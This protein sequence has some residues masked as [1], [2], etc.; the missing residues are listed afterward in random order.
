[1]PNYIKALKNGFDS[2]RRA[3]AAKDSIFQ[4]FTEL[5]EQIGPET[6]N[7][8]KIKVHRKQ[9]DLDPFNT[10]INFFNRPEHY[11]ALVAFNPEEKSPDYIEI[12]TW[13]MDKMGFPCRISWEGQEHI[14]EDLESLKNCFAELISDPLV[15]Q[16]LFSL[17]S[18]ETKSKVQK[19]N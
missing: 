9:K 2:A 12:A 4:A 3:Q 17:F 18:K 1:M 19:P 7:R 13:K 8:V 10:A 5:N 15:G 11:E 6:K 16:K 14:C